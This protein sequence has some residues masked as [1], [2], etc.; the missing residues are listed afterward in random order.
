MLILQS[1]NYFTY[2]VKF[3][4]HFKDYLIQGKQSI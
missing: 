4:E 3:D 2:S 1:S